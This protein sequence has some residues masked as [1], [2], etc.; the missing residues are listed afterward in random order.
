MPVL[1]ALLLASVIAAACSPAVFSGGACLGPAP[2]GSPGDPSIPTLVDHADVI[3]L[4]TV[5]RTE[6]TNAPGNYDDQG[7]RR[8]T[9]RTIQSARG[10]APAE[11][12]VVDGP[13]PMLMA[14]PG[15]TLIAFLE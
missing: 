5:V 10:A 13:C 3:V 8:V 7:A 9:L 1:R 6:P 14:T 15:E 11:F 2:Q 4:A 12:V